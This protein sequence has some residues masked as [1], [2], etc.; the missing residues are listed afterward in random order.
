MLDALERKSLI[1]RQPSDRRK[2]AI[3]L[4][5]EGKRLIEEILPIGQ[6]LGD[7]AISGL[8]GREVEAL[9]STLNKIYEN[10]S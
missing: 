5:A 8:L 1:F 7:K 10:I 4:T 3:F 2:Y 9:A 6:E